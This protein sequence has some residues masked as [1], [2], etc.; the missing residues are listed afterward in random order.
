M[1]ENLIEDRIIELL[2]EVF[3][4]EH[5]SIIAFP[6]RPEYE[7][8]VLNWVVRHPLCEILVDADDIDYTDSGLVQSDVG[9]KIEILVF[10]SQRRGENGIREICKTIRHALTSNIIEGNQLRPTDQR[11]IMYDGSHW[12]YGQ[13]Y[14]FDSIYTMGE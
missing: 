7:D 4:E 1:D 2:K 5:A 11:K 3:D 12:C 8:G 13:H 14:S 10:S 9:I 6:D